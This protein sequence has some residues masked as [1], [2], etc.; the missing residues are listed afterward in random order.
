MKLDWNDCEKCRDFKECYLIA[1]GYDG[2]N[3]TPDYMSA[4]RKRDLCVNNGKRFFK[5]K[6]WS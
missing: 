1:H 2:L 6:E 3:M 4:I 5:L